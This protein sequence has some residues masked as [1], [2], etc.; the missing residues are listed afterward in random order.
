MPLKLL[1]RGISSSVDIFHVVV[2]AAPLAL[3]LV[4]P[5]EK[6]FLEPVEQHFDLLNLVLFIL[7]LKRNTAEGDRLSDLVMPEVRS[8]YISLDALQESVLGFNVS[9]N[10]D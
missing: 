7:N 1:W 3:G 10:F 6:V 4:A 9:R 5:G 8:L 2:G